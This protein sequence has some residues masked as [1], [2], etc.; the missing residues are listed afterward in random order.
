MMESPGPTQMDH[1]L[2]HDSGA[3][4]FC[5]RWSADS[6]GNMSTV[7]PKARTIFAHH[8]LLN[9]THTIIMSVFMEDIVTSQ[10]QGT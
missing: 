3:V 1:E 5:T 10:T 8:L 2:R 4:G 7:L 6:I 9:D